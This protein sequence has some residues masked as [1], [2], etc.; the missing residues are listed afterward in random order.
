MKTL[1]QKFL[2]DFC[3]FLSK[4]NRVK[5]IPVPHLRGHDETADE[6]LE[7]TRVWALRLDSAKGNRCFPPPT[8]APLTGDMDHRV[9]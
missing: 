6:S 8:L 7:G 3:V 9:L 5:N 1:Y 4:Y 2:F